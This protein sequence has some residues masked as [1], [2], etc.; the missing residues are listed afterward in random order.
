MKRQFVSTCYLIDQGKFLLHFHE[1]HQKWLPPGGHLEENET[2]PQA[3]RREV[4]EETGLKIEFFEE[5]H[6]VYDQWNA[7]S[8]PRPFAC[9]LETIPQRG[10]E[11]AHEHIDCIFVARPISG[12]LI[13]GFWFTLEEIMKLTPHKEI[14]LDTQ[15]VIQK[16]SKL[17]LESSE[18]EK[19]PTSK[20]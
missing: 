13:Q 11:P 16:L 20:C 2:P 12:K 14:F 3:A 9:L 5:E 17:Y 19:F 18:S 8:I 1:K 10:K 15:I 6:L 4:F 7:H